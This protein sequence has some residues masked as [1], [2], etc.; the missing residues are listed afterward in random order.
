MIQLQTQH[1]QRPVK[2]QRFEKK[3]A[4]TMLDISKA[5]CI[6]SYMESMLDDFD[7]LV[8]LNIND[9]VK[10]GVRKMLSRHDHAASAYFNK[11]SC[12]EMSNIITKNIDT[13]REKTAKSLSS[14]KLD[15]HRFVLALT[16]ELNELR[17]VLNTLFDQGSTV[18]S[19][20]IKGLVNAMNVWLEKQ[21]FTGGADIHRKKDLITGTINGFIKDIL[22]IFKEEA[23][24]HEH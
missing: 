23:S 20:T 9:R 19:N 22:V 7:R 13:F 3:N 21:G 18:Y 17:G 2:L 6:A 16:Y 12:L 11:P 1:A 5:V 14:K 15:D 10:Q 24:N 8:S 4:Y